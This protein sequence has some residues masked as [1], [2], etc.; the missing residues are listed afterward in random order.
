[1]KKEG[2]RPKFRSAAKRIAYDYLEMQR[3]NAQR[4]LRDNKYKLLSLQKEQRELKA[5]IAGLHQV[6]QEFKK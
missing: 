1:M 3:N 6:I 4:L 2:N 5:D